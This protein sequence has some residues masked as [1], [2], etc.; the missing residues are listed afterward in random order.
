MRPSMHPIQRHLSIAVTFASFICAAKAQVA[1]A[2]LINPEAPG[3]QP[4]KHR[5][6]SFTTDLFPLTNF[7]VSGAI[8]HGGGTHSAWG[9]TVALNATKSLSGGRNFSLGGWYFHSNDSKDLYQVQ[10]AL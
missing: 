5:A 8:G 10:G 1:Q 3:G 9:Q 2:D 6:L 7:S 4:G